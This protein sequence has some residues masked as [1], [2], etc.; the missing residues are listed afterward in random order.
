MLPYRR[1]QV[2][3]ILCEETI[4]IDNFKDNYYNRKVVKIMNAIVAE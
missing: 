4:H 3:K 2:K 1:G